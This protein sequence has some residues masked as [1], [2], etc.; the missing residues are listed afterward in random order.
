[1][2]PPVTLKSQRRLQMPSLTCS[3]KGCECIF[4]GKTYCYIHYMRFFRTGSANP[5]KPIQ[6]RFVH[7]MRNHPMYSLWHNMKQ[8]CNNPNRAVYPHYGGRGIQ[9]CKRWDDFRLF[10]D[11]MGERPDGMTLERIN[12]DGNYTPEN[13]KWATMAEQRLN[14]RP[15][16]KLWRAE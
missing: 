2:K 11:D 7:G 1:M 15:R 4:Y 16:R 14:Q 5:D 12:N 6:P 13:C 3:V 8:R 10:L 9:V